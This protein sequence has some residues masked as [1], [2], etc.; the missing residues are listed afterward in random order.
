M[1]FADRQTYLCHLLAWK[2]WTTWATP[3]SLDERVKN[4]DADAYGIGLLS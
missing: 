4:G 2:L 3:L 1:R